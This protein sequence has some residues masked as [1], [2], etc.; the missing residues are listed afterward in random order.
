[1]KLLFCLV[2]FI[3]IAIAVH[4]ACPKDPSEWCKTVEAANDCQV[5]LS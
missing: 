1:M 4:S 2:V 3:S 5:D